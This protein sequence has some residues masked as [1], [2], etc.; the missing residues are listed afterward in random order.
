MNP[1]PR[2][3]ATMWISSWRDDRSTWEELAAQMR[4][5]VV[6][7]CATIILADGQ[8]ADVV[9]VAKLTPADVEGLRIEIYHRH[10]HLAVLHYLS[11]R[12]PP[13]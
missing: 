8:P 10:L 2:L 5:W 4:T 1:L 6:G 3:L 11:T 12:H 7:G 13:A 9:T